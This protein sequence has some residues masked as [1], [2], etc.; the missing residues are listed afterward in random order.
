MKLEYN[1]FFDDRKIQVLLKH[2]ELLF[3]I[4]KFGVLVHEISANLYT[5]YL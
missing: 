1:Y 4:L 3:I 2:L 5:K